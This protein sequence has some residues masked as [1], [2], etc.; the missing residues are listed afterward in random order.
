[1]QRKKER[2]TSFEFMLA[3]TCITCNNESERGVHFV[4]CTE[5]VIVG[6]RKFESSESNAC[7]L[8]NGHFLISYSFTGVDKKA[9]FADRY[10]V[11]TEDDKPCI[12]NSYP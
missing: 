3:V 4:P 8:H 7:N 9:Q 6:T 5:V 2:N 11:H 1:M 10:A 12:V